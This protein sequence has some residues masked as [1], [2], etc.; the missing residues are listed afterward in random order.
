MNSVQT[1]SKWYV[2]YKG[3]ELGTVK[4]QTVE[5]ATRYAKFK[6]GHLA[7]HATESFEITRSEFGK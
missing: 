6:W 3:L 1:W 7:S 5:E 4:A 2:D